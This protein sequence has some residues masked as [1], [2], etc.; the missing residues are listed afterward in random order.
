MQLFVQVRKHLIFILADGK[1]RVVGQQLPFHL[2]RAD[3][4]ILGSF[5]DLPVEVGQN[6]GGMLAA[7]CVKRGGRAPRAATAA[8]RAATA[9]VSC[10]DGSPTPT[11]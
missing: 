11:A 5:A 9:S 7:F 3:F 8:S 2:Q 10:R 6:L 4:R 1:V